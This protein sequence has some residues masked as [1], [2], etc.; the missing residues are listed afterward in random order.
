MAVR[1]G[2]SEDAHFQVGGA[3][4][5]APSA[6]P[7]N[8]AWGHLAGLFTNLQIRNGEQ[9]RA[10]SDERLAETVVLISSAPRT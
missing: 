3:N 5:N 10:Q 8:G 4:P 1:T 6:D 2:H 7:N 9:V